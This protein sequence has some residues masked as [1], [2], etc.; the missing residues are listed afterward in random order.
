MK[1]EMVLAGLGS[2]PEQQNEGI[3]S[4]VGRFN[5]DYNGIYLFEALARRDGSSRLHPDFRWSNFYGASAGINLAELPILSSSNTFDILKLRASWGQTGSTAGISAYDYVSS[6]AT[7]TAVFGVSPGFAN[8]ANIAGISTIDRT[9]ERVSTTNFALDFGLL[10]YRLT[11][12]FEYFIRENDDMLINITYPDVL[13]ASA[14]LTN[15]GSFTTKGWELAL[16]WRDKIGQLEYNVGFMFW[17]AVSEV[18]SLEGAVA[19]GLGV[20]NPIE[21]KPLNSIY[22]Y[23]TDGILQTEA[24]VLEYYQQYGFA[25]GDVN[26]MKAGTDLPAYNTSSSFSAW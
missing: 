25:G 1:D 17:D 15:S 22:T 13:G 10:N 9:W 20:N 3:L 12:S 8:T 6:I 24:E 16:N 14:P 21:G 5:Y 7:G 18:T 11:G 4:Y 26:T 2:G 23:Q 19:I